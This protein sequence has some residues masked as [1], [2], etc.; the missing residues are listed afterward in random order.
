M[1]MGG[2]PL[3]SGWAA[4]TM[5]EGE[6][7]YSPVGYHLGTVWPHDNSLIAWGLRR[8]GYRK[9]AARI[10]AG[11]VQAAVYFEG[12]LPEAFADYR[13]SETQFPVEYPTACSP[14]AWST[15]APLLLLRALLGL[16]PVGGQLLVDAA[17]PDRVGWLELLN[18][19][20][21][22]GRTDAFAR[23]SVPVELEPVDLTMSSSVSA[24]Q[25]TPAHA[26]DRA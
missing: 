9:E 21:A 23:G 10:A 5:A 26:S 17:L 20:G 15:G 7:G 24:A 14:H 13:R 19:P 25:R 1:S 11:I 16:K 2:E 12:R 3:F 8:S 6:G 22:W 4:R 18:I